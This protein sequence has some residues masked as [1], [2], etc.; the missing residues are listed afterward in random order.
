MNPTLAIEK[1]P[2]NIHGLNVQE[3][4]ESLNSSVIPEQRSTDE[5]S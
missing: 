5:L 2:E 1:Q 3:L 4:G